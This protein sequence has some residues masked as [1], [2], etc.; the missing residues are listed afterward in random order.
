LQSGEDVCWT[1]ERLAALVAEIKSRTGMKITLS[2]GV[3]TREE[4]EILKKAGASN[5]LL[6]IETTNREIF[7]EIHPDDDYDYRLQCSKWLKE[8]GYINGSGN[9][10]GL[11]GQK[12]EDIAGDILFFKQMGINM[13]GIGPFIPAKGTKY[14]HL[15]HGDVDLTLRTVAVTRI[16]CK[17]V[18]IPST[19]ALASLNKDAQVWALEAGANTIM[20]I[21]TPEKYRGNYR[22]YDN[23]NMVDLDSAIYAISKAGRKFP[24]YLK[25]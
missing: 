13:I 7:K 12:E 2:V 24:A 19:T 21:S 16:V 20:L 8:L 23:K 5:Y 4:Y 22:I 3:K 11:L 17:R 1:T 18:Y 9:I 15:P 14:E 6:K 25:L 10:I